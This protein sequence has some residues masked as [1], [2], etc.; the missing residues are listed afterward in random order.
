M[1]PALRLLGRVL[2]RNWLAITLGRHVWAWRPLTDAELAH[3]LAHVAQ[4]ARYGVTFPI[5]Y[6]LASLRARRAGKRWYEDNHFEIEA[7]RAAGRR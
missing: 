2:I 3:E 7:R 1:Y 4:W 5:A 6:G